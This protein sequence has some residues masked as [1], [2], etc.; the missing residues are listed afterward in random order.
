MENSR[1]RIPAD[2]KRTI[3][4]ES[5][6]RCAIATCRY[7][8]T[9]IAHIEPWSKVREHKYEN[10]IALC[11]NCHTRAD[12]KNEID[13]KSLRI[14]KE[15]IRFLSDKFTK[16]EMNVLSYLSRKEKVIVYGELSVKNLLDNELI[17]N[18]HTICHFTYSD[19]TVENQEFVVTLTKIGKEFVSNWQDQDISEFIY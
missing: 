2:L 1:P 5:G 12:Q 8:T 11:P 3:L 6:H 4:V 9:E 7:P 17:T 13:K 16:H 10:L 19:G 18:S 14:Y 15:K